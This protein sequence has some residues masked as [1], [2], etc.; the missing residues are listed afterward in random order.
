[1]HTL[2]GQ[3]KGL[4]AMIE[5]KEYEIRRLHEENIVQTDQLGQQRALATELAPLR[6]EVERLREELRVAE[7]RIHKAELQKNEAQ[8]QTE[9]RNIEVTQLETLSQHHQNTVRDR[10]ETINKITI[11]LTKCE[12]EGRRADELQ[13]QLDDVLTRAEELR[14]SETA[15]AEQHA[16]SRAECEATQRKVAELEAAGITQTARCD[17]LLAELGDSSVQQEQLQT[18]NTQ[19]RAEEERLNEVV[20]QLR[21]SNSSLTTQ[22][23]ALSEAGT[24]HQ[25]E[26]RELRDSHH[27]SELR[28]SDLDNA[29]ASMELELK[30]ERERTQQLGQQVQSIP[31]LESDIAQLQGEVAEMTA[32]YSDK[33][34]EL[35]TKTQ[36]A[37]N[38]RMR[39]KSLE[40]AAIRSEELAHTNADLLNRI[41]TAKRDVVEME[42]VL[43]QKG[44]RVRELETALKSRTDE[45]NTMSEQMSKATEDVKELRE[46]C[47][48]LEIERERALTLQGKLSGM[49]ETLKEKHNALDD[50]F[51]ENTSLKST[52][53]RLEAT[54][55]DRA[56][57]TSRLASAEDELSST[58]DT[59]QRLQAEADKNR[60]VQSDLRDEL[61]EVKGKKQRL[62]EEI[63]TAT[64]HRYREN[65]NNNTAFW[66]FWVYLF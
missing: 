21:T 62:E 1:M 7:E 26:A 49:D 46:R 59:L 15:L 34:H 43:E 54:V 9:A 60:R 37:L 6:G 28:I 23:G 58:H 38:V 44:Q 4:E 45:H 65:N 24:T 50:A 40:S 56:H 47:T 55:A 57:D 36:E 30:L 14:T 11:E 48:H 18:L 27:Q 31:L 2:E 25:A 51:E 5:T 39:V 63:S 16:A 35:A 41:T 33:T 42:A 22:V 52:I 17:A 13:R 32:A 12:H 10:D 66:G 3:V 8:M 20:T 64:A 61:E 19:L 53:A 29:C